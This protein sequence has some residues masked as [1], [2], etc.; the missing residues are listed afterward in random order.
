[1]YV[2]RLQLDLLSSSKSI[3]NCRGLLEYLL[4]EIHVEINLLENLMPLIHAK[5]IGQGKGKVEKM[6]I[7]SAKPCFPAIKRRSSKNI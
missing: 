3:L 5:R 2:Q 1:M 7:D 6:L 4:K